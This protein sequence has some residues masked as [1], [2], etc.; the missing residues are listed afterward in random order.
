MKKSIIFFSIIFICLVNISFAQ[1]SEFTIQEKTIGKTY[2]NNKD[3]K[4]KDYCFLSNVEHFDIDSINNYALIQLRNTTKDG[5]TLKSD[6]S[7]PII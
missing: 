4:V 5:K 3:I 7:F 6:G 1:V 2:L